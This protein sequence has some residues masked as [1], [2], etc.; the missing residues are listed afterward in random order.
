MCRIAQFVFLGLVFEVP[1]EDIL[2]W[3]VW[4]AIIGLFKA[5]IWSAQVKLEQYIV[6]FPLAPVDPALRFPW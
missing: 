4:F 1:F 2:Y 6:R 5:L 3:L